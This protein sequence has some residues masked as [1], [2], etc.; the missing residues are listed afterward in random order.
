MWGSEGEP[1]AGGA[2]GGEAGDPFTE[3]REDPEVLLDASRAQGSSW[4]LSWLLPHFLA[5]SLGLCATEL[6][7]GLILSPQAP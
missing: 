6:T 1:A 5:S 7:K 4:R 2:A 3:G